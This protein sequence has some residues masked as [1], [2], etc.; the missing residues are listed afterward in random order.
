M[1]S[2]VTISGRFQWTIEAGSWAVYGGFGQRRMKMEEEGKE[3]RKRRPGG[4]SE[5]RL[6][7]VRKRVASSGSM[8]TE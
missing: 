8:C 4:P 6:G 7:Q 1:D 2:K 3:G 5:V